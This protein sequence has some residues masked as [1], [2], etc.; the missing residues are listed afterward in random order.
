MK[1]LHEP[2]RFAPSL[3]DPGPR[4]ELRMLQW[5]LGIS[6]AVHLI[7]ILVDMSSWLSFGQSPVE[8]WVLD[9][10][11]VGDLDLGGVKETALPNAVKD[12][13][14]AMQN[15]LPQ[16]PKT[17]AVK[18]EEK[19]DD[20]T[21]PDLDK[22]KELEKK[23]QEKQVT[24]P[25]QENANKISM[26][27]LRKRKALE[28]MRRKLKERSITAR[29][30]TKAEVAGIRERL[31]AGGVLGGG[32]SGSGPFRKC[33]AIMKKMV[34]DSFAVPDAYG[35]RGSGMVVTFSVILAE[36]GNVMKADIA[37]SS[38]N[39]VFDDYALKALHDSA[40]FPEDCKPM[41][42]TAVQFNFKP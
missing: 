5:L 30:P 3:P 16:L 28:D 26:D 35:I 13:D 1:A 18:D 7:V 39:T 10:D 33:L 22:Q 19:P 24:P 14:P 40:P 41:A 2:S 27:E 42:G 25:D 11:L 4:R 17:F 31:A 8:E 9:A 23:E 20:D 12:E 36:N 37:R 38:G 21:M 15:L 34:G 32:G 29:A 6:L